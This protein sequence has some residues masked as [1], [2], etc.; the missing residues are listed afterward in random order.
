MLRKSLSIGL[1]KSLYLLISIPILTI[2]ACTI[3]NMCLGHVLGNIMFPFPTADLVARDYL[4]NL[5]IGNTENL[6]DLVPNYQKY[7]GVEVRNIQTKAESQSGNSDHLYEVVTVEFEY[8]DRLTVWQPDSFTLMTD[9][10][11]ERGDSLLNNLPFRKV[12]N[13]GWN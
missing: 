8:R 3:F 11:I 1:K 6:G 12:I 2:L 13:S 10:N 9:S 5:V 4:N 7:R